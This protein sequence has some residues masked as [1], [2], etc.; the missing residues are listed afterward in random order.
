MRDHKVISL[1]H[2][3][4]IVSATWQFK[5]FFIFVGTIIRI[6]YLIVHEYVYLQDMSVVD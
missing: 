2:N 3:W 1:V 5:E 4:N 6:T